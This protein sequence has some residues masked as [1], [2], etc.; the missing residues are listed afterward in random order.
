MRDRQDTPQVSSSIA[1]PPIPCAV[2]DVALQLSLFGESGSA[3]AG[4]APLQHVVWPLQAVNGRARAGLPYAVTGMASRAAT[5]TARPANDSLGGVGLTLDLGAGAA[6][7]R[8]GDEARFLYRVVEGS[9]FTYRL[10]ADGRRQITGFH[11]PGDVFG[12]GIDGRHI[13]GA[14]AIRRS[15]VRRHR[16]VALKAMMR[17]GPRLA[18]WLQHAAESELLNSQDH[19]LLLGQRTAQERVVGFLLQMSCRAERRGEAGNPVRLPMT[20]G[21]IA[22]F[23]GLTI[24]TVSRSFTQLRAAGLIALQG[25]YLVELADRAALRAIANGDDVPLAPTEP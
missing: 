17:S 21:H 1:A 14:E 13:Y 5:T 11:F 12:V 24:E 10:T 22:D 20:R 8:E 19:V 25:Y 4:G 2:P 9:V 6:L 16:H 7:F 3:A 15:R 23:L 18:A